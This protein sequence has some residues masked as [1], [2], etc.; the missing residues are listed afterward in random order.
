MSEGIDPAEALGLGVE[1]ALFRDPLG[2][3]Y[4]LT[5]LKNIDDPELRRVFGYTF[6]ELRLGNLD[7]EETKLVQRLLSLA[8][9]DIKIGQHYISNEEGLIP[10]A[11][12]LL[13][14][15]LGILIPTRSRGGFERKLQAT[16]IKE[17]RDNLV[18][19]EREKKRGILGFLLGRE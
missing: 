9:K 8:L 10:T 16:E 15:V 12:F 17:I 13:A 2:L 19:M 1:S 3:A 7:K 5:I 14:E 18:A 6:A 4:K 11:E